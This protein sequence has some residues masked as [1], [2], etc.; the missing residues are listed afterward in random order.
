MQAPD[1][2]AT[3]NPTSKRKR[4]AAP[5]A[6]SDKKFIYLTPM[7]LQSTGVVVAGSGLLKNK[8]EGKQRKKGPCVGT[9]GFR[10][11]EELIKS[12]HQDPKVDIWSVGVTL[13]YFIIGRTPFVGDPDQNI[14][15]IVKL[16]G[17]ED[18]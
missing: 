6:K 17:S 11:P 18:L 14:K 5:P 12:T 9:K 8:G 1:H 15:E 4:A 16:R 3:N 13:L 7:P 10:A 2:E